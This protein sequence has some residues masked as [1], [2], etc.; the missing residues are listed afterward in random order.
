MA[1][2]SRRIARRVAATAVS[3]LFG[4]A[5][6]GAFYPAHFDPGGTGSVPG[7]TGDAVFD[8]S[9]GC[10]SD[11]W[12]PATASGPCTA[13]LFSATTFLYSLSPS[14]PPTP[15]IVL[16]SFSLSSGD[17]LGVLAAGGAITGVDTDPMGPAPGT[18]AYSTNSFWLQFVSGACDPDV[19]TFTPGGGDLGGGELFA[20]VKEEGDPAFIFM[21]E[22]DLA[23]RNGPAT[24]IF[25]PACD[26]PTDCVVVAQ[27]PEPG[28]LSLLL[29]A[30]GA[31]WLARRRR[32][33]A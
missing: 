21:D 1:Q 30:L 17:V 15:G 23:H 6:Y 16:G 31:G 9:A 14:D 27:V 28:V 32:P 26:D 29:A 7:F 24:V 19:C 11:G 13:S 18:G 33:P 25:G 8:I 12:K 5:A 20:A 4:T 2:K 10:L 3:L 22:L